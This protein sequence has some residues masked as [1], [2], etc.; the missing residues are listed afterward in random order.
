GNG[1]GD[2]KSAAYQLTI[3]PEYGFDVFKKNQQDVYSVNTPFTF[4]LLYKNLGGED[5]SKGDFIDILPFNGDSSGTISGLSSERTPPSSFDGF[6]RVTKL[7]GTNNEVFYATNVNSTTIKNDPCH[8][9]NQAAGYTPVVGDV[10]YT[11]YV[12]NGN[13]WS[14]GSTLGTGNTPW[15]QCSG[16][17]PVVCGGLDSK[18]ITGIR[19][20]VDSVTAAAGGKTVEIELTPEGNIGGTPDIDTSSNVT[21]ESTGDIYTNTFSGRVPE[22]S[23]LVISNDASV[24]MVSGSIGDKIFLDNDNSGIQNAGDTPIANVTVSLLDN[25]GNPVYKDPATGAIVNSTYPGAVVYTTTTDPNG[26]YLF[27]NL[28][29][30]DYSVVVDQTT[31]PDN[32]SQVYD[33]DTT[34]D[35]QSTHTL[36]AEMNIFGEIEDIEN[37]TD[38]DFGY[39]P[40]S[41]IGDT[42]WI[43]SNADGVQDGEELGFSGATLNLLDAGGNIIAT[44]Q[45]DSNGNY[46]FDDLEPGDYKV[47]LVMPTDYILSSDTQ[48]TNTAIDSDILTN[49]KTDTITLGVDEHRTDIDAG[50]Y[51]QAHI[52]DYVWNDLD[53]DGI[54][55]SGETGVVGVVVNLLDING[56]VVATTTTDT[57]G[58]YGFD[59][60]PGT[61]LV[62]FIKP[63]GYVGAPEGNGS[64]STGS[65]ADIITGQTDSIIVASG[66]EIDNIDTGIYVPTGSLGDRVWVD[67]NADGIQDAG[68][69]GVQGVTVELLD[70]NSDVVATT[71]TDENGNYLFED[72]VTGDY[73]IRFSDL[74]T[75]YVFSPEN[76]GGV[77][78]DS[79]ANTTTGETEVF[80][81][82][83][84]DSILSIDAGIYTTASIGD[85]VWF[86]DNKDGI[87]DAGESGIEGVVVNLLD[88]NGDVITTTT[89]DSNG[90]YLFDNLIPGE[91]SVEVVAPTGYVISP[92]TNTTDTTLDSNID[93]ITGQT[94]TII[95][96][97]GEHIRDVDAGLYIPTASI[98]DKVWYDTNGDGI[99]DLGEAG[100]EGVVVNLI[101][102][103]GNVVA[104]TTTDSN[105]NYLFEDVVAGDYTVEFIPPADHIFSPKNAGDSDFDS[106]VNIETGTTETITVNDRDEITDIDAGL[107]IP[108][109]LSGTVIHDLNRGGTQDTGEEPI[110][111]VIIELLDANG[112]V[113]A[114]TTTDANGDYSFEGLRPGDYRVKITRPS[115]FNSN[116]E[117]N[118]GPD[119]TKDFDINSQG[120]TS[121]ISLL[122]GD[123]ITNIDA[124]FYKRGGGRSS[125]I[126]STSRIPNTVTPVNA[127]REQ[128]QQEEVSPVQEK[129][130]ME[131]ISNK[132]QVSETEE[133]LDISLLKK[134]YVKYKIQRKKLDKII[135]YENT[136][137]LGLT[138]FPRLLPQTGTPI[139][140][141]MKTRKNPKVDTSLPDTKIFRLAGSKN[142]D[143]NFWKTVLP[144]QDRN[145]DEYIV[146]PSNGLVVPINN[147][148]N[149]TADF[150]K[151][152]SGKEIKVNNYLKTGVMSYPGSSK[153]DFG[154]LGNKVIFGHSS[155]WKKDDGRYKTHFQKIIEL[156]T[157]E[158]VWVYKKINGV[159]KRFR[160]RVEKSYNTPQSDT[161]VLKPGYGSNL[162]LFTCTPIGG[163]EGRWII[164]AKYINED[165]IQLQKA[166]EGLDIATKYKLSINKI[167]YKLSK[168]SGEKK[169]KII[170]KIYTRI[171]KLEAKQTNKQKLDILKYLKIRLLIEYFEK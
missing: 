96:G 108:A 42:V 156:D 152:I 4:E 74:P 147:V 72:V 148:P 65:D 15:I 93:I 121:T 137:G 90:N 38:Q 106:N 164:K 44:T 136:Q 23:L 105:G 150:S 163:I 50:I 91:Y 116:S 117:K 17:N 139:S 123:N 27:E 85:T 29:E 43:D 47:E 58:E 144:E 126:R 45:T 30:G 138:S 69:M 79:N 95:L 59:V 87:Q 39:L 77:D 98:G 82:N 103:N 114:T 118:I 170:L 84:N 166:I 53:K 101:D 6:Y 48:G 168:Y 92:E 31:L 25:A 115:E 135:K 28:P 153:N 149:D 52:G 14:G 64:D 167:V 171:S 36:V 142:S 63:T 62:E 67:T 113:I 81:L 109:S 34:L 73:S 60:D 22:I 61:Y 160:Y 129:A 13:K 145:G 3:L 10:C 159:F 16:V 157:G 49:L 99:Q 7:E 146:I 130:Q 111:G 66:D 94:E 161:S 97:S 51:K 133:E 35:S 33:P 71:T 20:K 100:I 56:D 112:N 102:E 75:D 21:S 57:N 41:S 12:N 40:L 122:P 88:E 125:S 141:R 78:G 104:T 134:D 86:D 54:Q 8:E 127:P 11:S 83:D 154:E 24:T 155:Y 68:E 162:T 55:D 9:D 169:K 107:F 2:S 110:E 120:K 19:F 140:E 151:M 37:N 32:V 5:Y 80:T 70:E 26:N 18:D 1:N 131:E 132:E 46:L 158:E 128:I 143:L 119:I 76:V 124:G 165:K 89:T